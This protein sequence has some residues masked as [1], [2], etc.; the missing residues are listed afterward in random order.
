MSEFF[1]D[2]RLEEINPLVLYVMRGVPGSGKSHVA[3]S[4]VPPGNVFSA[5]DFFGNS[6]EEYI[7]NWK[8][9]SLGEAHALCQSRCRDAM[10]IKS[11][12]LCVDNTNILSRDVLPY[13]KLALQYGYSLEI[14]EPTSPWWLQI[15]PLLVRKNMAE[16][17]AAAL[18]LFEKCRH[19]VPLVTIRR[20]LGRWDVNMSADY[21]M[22]LILGEKQ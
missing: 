13:V 3:H 10:R 16:L 19:G 12:P 1:L 2:W 5:D 20:M 7:R 4:L 15:R 17:D 18:T 14:R 6:L 8:Y 22:R 21:M 11:S 9:E